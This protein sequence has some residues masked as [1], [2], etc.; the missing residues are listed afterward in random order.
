[1]LK[2]IHSVTIKD[3]FDYIQKL[4]ENTKENPYKV[5]IIGGNWE[6]EWHRE[7]LQQCTKIENRFVDL[8][9][10]AFIGT[11]SSLHS[12]F[13]YANSLVKSP[14]L[15]EGVTDLSFCFQDCPA[16]KEAPLIPEGVV[17]MRACFMGCISLV[18]A[19]NIPKSA[20]TLSDLFYGCISLEKSPRLPEGITCLIGR[21]Y[22][23]WKLK[24]HRQYRMGCLL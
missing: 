2:H 8:S 23:C 4:P 13:R 6:T 18:K 9:K 5:R 20:K 16:L 21:F 12:F 22:K 19:H 11:I 7:T 3:V 17:D 1:M 24:K 15:P 10:T 14:M